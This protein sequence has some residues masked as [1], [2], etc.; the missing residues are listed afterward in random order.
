MMHSES[1]FLE[2]TVLINIVIW[3]E[4]GED[5]I[6]ESRLSIEKTQKP[7]DIYGCG[8]SL[9]PF[10]VEKCTLTLP[11]NGKWFLLPAGNTRKRNLRNAAIYDLLAVLKK[12]F[13]WGYSQDNLVSCTIHSA[14][15]SLPI[16]LTLVFLWSNF[17]AFVYY[18][19]NC[20][21]LFFLPYT[22]YSYK[23]CQFLLWLN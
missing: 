2:D 10:S 8:N 21:V 3:T 14:H 18:A 20:F 12:K 6:L 5:I 9:R 4:N 23:C 13:F 16:M 22:C 1:G 15:F 7:S 17:A 19:I 11:D